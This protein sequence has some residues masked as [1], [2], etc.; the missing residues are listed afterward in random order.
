M[1]RRNYGDE[2]YMK[3]TCGLLLGESDYSQEIPRYVL[4]QLLIDAKK[5]MFAGERSL[6]GIL[7]L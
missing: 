7:T 4:K 5:F 6:T 3:E 1:I 2:F